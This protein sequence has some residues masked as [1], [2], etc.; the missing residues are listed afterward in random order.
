MVTWL[1]PTLIFSTIFERFNVFLPALDF[2]LKL[3]LVLLPVVA[4]ILFLKRRLTFN[5]TFL[6][7]FFALLVVVQILSVPFSFDAFQSFQVVVSTLLMI[8]LFYLT[9]WSTREGRDLTRLVWA[10]GVGAAMVS[11]LGLWQFFRYVGGQDPTLFFERW[12]GAKTLPATTFVQSLYGLVGWDVRWT[13]RLPDHFLRP[14]S[15]FIDV[16]TAASFVG[17]FLL[18]GVGWF[19]SWPKKSRERL[20]TAVLLIFSSLYFAISLSRSAVL[21][22]LVGTGLLAYLLLRERVSTRKLLVG[23]ATFLLLTVGGGF[24]V[25]SLSAE[26]SGSNVA[27][28][29]YARV[30]VEMF[31]KNPFVGVGAGNF[32]PYCLSVLHPDF[33]AC[34]SHSIILTWIGEL[35][36]LGVLA[37]LALIVVT[38]VFIWR[39]LRNRIYN[40]A[41][42]IRLSALL[43]G[44]IALVTA[45]IFHAHYG[46]DFTWVLLGLASVGYYLAKPSTASSQQS[47]DILGVRVDNV[48]INEAADRVKDLFKSG[49]KSY[50]VTPNPEMVVQ[51]RKDKEFK[52]VLNGADLSIPDGAGLVWASRIWGNPLKERVSGTDLFMELCAESSRRGGQVFLLGGQGGVAEKAAQ[53]LKNRYP[54]LKITGTFAGDG[55]PAGDSETVSSIRQAV[56]SPTRPIDLLFVAYGHGKQERWIKRN[57]SKVPVKVAMGVGGAFD[58]VAGGQKRA[59]RLVRALGFEWLYRLARQPWRI[60]RQKALV[61]FILLTFREALR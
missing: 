16:S 46:L 20:F 40:R 31:K 36:I 42:Y 51:S 21:G 55:S 30:A 54:K 34:Y 17:L 25:S 9:V 60:K 48:T 59:P 19:L 45:N 8:G 44:F 50:V 3:S 47:V 14:P 10:W 5:P 41:L 11:V 35:G 7:P 28:A 4:L 27:R 57:L 23:L 15:T 22:L 61:P 29:E 33:E 56:K 39:I 38:V 26:R 2:S 18:L 53:A 6:F 13:L 32:E 1:L 52:D 43:S 37:N 12:V 49:H 24:F 58:F